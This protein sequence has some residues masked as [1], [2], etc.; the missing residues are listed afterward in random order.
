MDPIV[1]TLYM[2]YLGRDESGSLARAFRKVMDGSGEDYNWDLF[3]SRIEDLALEMKWK[4]KLA[5]WYEGEVDWSAFTHRE[6]LAFVER[7]KNG[8]TEEEKDESN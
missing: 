7:Y 6:L 3:T 2:C 4:N 8:T 5:F 1:Y